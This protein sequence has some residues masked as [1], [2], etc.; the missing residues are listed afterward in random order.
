MLSQEGPQCCGQRAGIGFSVQEPQLRPAAACRGPKGQLRCGHRLF[1][2][3][4]WETVAQVGR[5]AV[6]MQSFSNCSVI[7]ACVCA[8]WW[9]K[10]WD[11]S[12]RSHSRLLSCCPMLH[13]FTSF[14]KTMTSNSL[15]VWLTKYPGTYMPNSIGKH[16]RRFKYVLLDTKNL[17]K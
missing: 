12:P 15:C 8:P 7:P 13:I 5:V 17:Q 9:L 16:L 3:S 11:R 10:S 6:S 4:A 1:M 2:T 14:H